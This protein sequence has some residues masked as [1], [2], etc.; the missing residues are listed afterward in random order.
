MDLTKTDAYLREHWPSA[1]LM[2]VVVVPTTWT[3]ARAIDTSPA[4]TAIVSQDVEARTRIEKVERALEAM[5]STFDSANLLY[6]RIRE[7]QEDEGRLSQEGAKTLK[8]PSDS[9]AA[10][11]S[12]TK[13]TL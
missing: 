2:L 12:G 9:A 8:T 6:K 7:D 11:P 4:T 10:V 5:R 1:L 13:G 3:V